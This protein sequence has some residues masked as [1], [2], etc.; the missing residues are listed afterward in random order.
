MKRIPTKKAAVIVGQ[1][2]YALLSDDEL[3]QLHDEAF[4]QG[5][6]YRTADGG[7]S[8]IKFHKEIMAGVDDTE[9]R[10]MSARRMLKMGMSLEDVEAVFRVKLE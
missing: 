2:D 5:I 7:F 9:L 3:N 1:I 6:R 10:K 8:D 4:N